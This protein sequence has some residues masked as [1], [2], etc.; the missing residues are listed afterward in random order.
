MIVP[1]AFVGAAL[2]VLGAFL[3]SPSCRSGSRARPSPTP[4]SASTSAPWASAS[5]RSCSSS[6]PSASGPRQ[7]VV[8]QSVA[9]EERTP[10]SSRLS[11]RAAAAGLGPAVTVGLATTLEPGHGARAVPVRTAVVAG[12]VAVVG[13]VAV[14]VVGASIHDLP[15]QPAP[16]A[17][18]GTRARAT[19]ACRATARP[20]RAPVCG[21]R[22][23]TTK[24]SPQRRRCASV[25]A[26]VDGHPVTRVRVRA[27]ERRRRADGA[28][29]PGTPDRPRGRARDRHARGRARRDRRHG[30]DRWPRPH[31][32]VPRRRARGPADLHRDQR[33][34]GRR[35]RGDADRC[36]CRID[37]ERRQHGCP[38]R[39]AVARRG[40]RRRGGMPGSA[41]RPGPGRPG[42]G[43]KIPLEVDRLEQVD[44]LPWVLG[45]F[46]AVIG[47]LGVAYAL[48]TGVRRRARELATLKT[49]G[50]RPPRSRR[51]SPSRRRCSPPQR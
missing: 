43:P 18:T 12:V 5:S 40:R 7:R 19:D 27:T 51:P 3:A 14:T 47:T 9:G 4:V 11:R 1:V 28:R 33:R 30:A 44:T 39:P 50:F 8:A 38:R 45:A 24:R 20:D 37:H 13:L 17:T 25:T 42:L 32:P 35:R 36:R 21:A 48:V 10:G 41:H 46:L 16:T 6:W 2:A 15:Q 26:E 31:A 23:P 29:G 22:S 34:A 49:L